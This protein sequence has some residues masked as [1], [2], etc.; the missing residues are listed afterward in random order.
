MKNC[1][2]CGNANYEGAVFCEHCGVSLGVVSIGTKK[3]GEN[4]PFSAGSEKLDNEHVLIIHFEDHEDPLTF[5]LNERAILGRTGGEN[6]RIALINLDGYGAEGH[7]VSR[8]HAMIER[9]GDRVYIADLG[10]TN[11]TYLNGQQLQE[12]DQLVL[13]DGDEL[14]LAHMRMKVFFK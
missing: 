10:S 9:Q 2:N 7:G 13:R 6:E 11:H 3:L 8:R 12:H 4:S 1:A 14:R 5:Q